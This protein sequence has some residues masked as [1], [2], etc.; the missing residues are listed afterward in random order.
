VTKDQGD[1]LTNIEMRINSLLPEYELQ[2]FEPTRMTREVRHVEQT[3]P[4]Y[5]PPEF[6]IP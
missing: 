4:A 5:E 6:H 1:Q 3:V 2:D